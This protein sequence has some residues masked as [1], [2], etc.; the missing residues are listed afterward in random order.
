MAA[1][2]ASL[3]PL[4][5]FEHKRY[6]YASSVLLQLLLSNSHFLIVLQFVWI[7]LNHHDLPV[8]FDFDLVGFEFERD[9]TYLDLISLSVTVMGNLVGYGWVILVWIIGNLKCLGSGFCLFLLL[10]FELPLNCLILVV[11]W[12]RFDGLLGFDICFIRLC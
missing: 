11:I 7:G 12:S 9:L 10:S 1:T 8:L 5:A 3:N 2:Q 6:A 4:V